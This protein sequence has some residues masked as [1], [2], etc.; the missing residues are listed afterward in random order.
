VAACNQLLGIEDA[1]VDARLSAAGRA[2]S[3]I[4]GTSS[5]GGT[6]GGSVGVEQGGSGGASGSAGHEETKPSSGTGGGTDETAGGGAGDEP[7]GSSKGGSQSHGSGGTKP[8]NGGSA[9]KPSSGNAGEAGDSSGMSSDPCDE[10]C[11][12]MESDCTGD[13]AQY[14]DR[15]Q[16]MTICHF[17][18]RGDAAQDDENSSECRL[19]YVRK[20][21]Y[22]LGAEVTAYCRQAG[23]SG[24]GKCGSVCDAFCSVMMQ[25]C[26]EQS[27]PD[28]HFASESD[29]LATCGALPAASV[30]YST[31]DPAVSD[32]NHALCRLFHVNSAAMADTEEHCEHAMGHTL[33]QAP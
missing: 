23:P 13:A 22:G 19:K 4:A 31:N 17:F 8:S 29:C 15:A 16:C 6:T 14:R 11:D 24:D 25:V 1:N 5:L 20:A 2:A 18:P 32:G 9:G 27:S 10:Y 3:A 28:N 21:R 33:C 12:E 26:T 7:S 30:P